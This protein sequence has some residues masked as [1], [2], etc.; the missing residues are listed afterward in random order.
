MTATTCTACH[1]PVAR[2]EA[3][4]RTDL[5]TVR[6]WHRACYTVHRATKDVD[7]A[8]VEADVCGGTLS[9]R[10]ERAGLL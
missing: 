3:I 9:E 2:N 5:R 7:A 6:A 4:Q 8:A 10:M 1:Q